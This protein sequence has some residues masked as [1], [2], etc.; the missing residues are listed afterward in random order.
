VERLA[1]NLIAAEADSWLA[2]SF[3]M[4]SFIRFNSSIAATAKEPTPTFAVT[5]AIIRCQA[6]A[7][8]AGVLAVQME[9][10]CMPI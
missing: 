2:R 8:C 7:F 5:A 6:S 9:G 10:T 3:M 4:G 1:K